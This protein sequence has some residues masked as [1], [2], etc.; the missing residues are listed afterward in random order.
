MH[1]LRDLLE[2]QGESLIVAGAAPTIKV[3][4]HTAHP[5]DVQTIAAKH[6]TLTRIKV[7]NMAEQHH[8][9]VVDARPNRSP[10]P[11]WCRGRGSSASRASWAPTSRSPCRT[12]RIRACE[13][14]L[15]GVNATLS[16]TVYSLPNDPNVALAAREV[17][18]L[19]TKTVIV[20][21]TRDIVR[22]LAV[23]LAFGGAETAPTEAEIL[24][25]AGRVR[26]A[27]LFF[28]G[29]DSSVD[30]VAV[31][32]HAPAATIDGALLTRSRS[33]R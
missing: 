2:P 9:L 16:D 15:V 33:R 24:A 14:L 21:P 19:T 26:A 12:T 30:G 28:A 23:Q 27:A 11:R 29:K 5:D 31:K 7:E 10:S 32:K 13:D 8:V 17:A 25:V 6:G 18:A 4:M 22:G 3:H 20:V 1:P